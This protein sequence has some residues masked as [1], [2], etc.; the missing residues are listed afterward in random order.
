MIRMPRFFAALVFAALLLAGL[1]PSAAL[2]DGFII[3]H[4]P[5][6]VPPGHFPFAPLEV[7]YHRVDVSIDEQ[8][9]ITSVDQEFHNPNPTRMEGTYLF[10]LP[11][12]AHLDSFKMDIDGRMAEA[13][14]LS[15]EK[16]R[17]IYED[18]VRRQRDPAL[19]E[20]IGREAL[21][22]RIFPIEPNSNKKIKLR[23]T[24]LLTADAGLVEYVY[25]L[26]TEK[27]SAKPLRDVSV[28]VSLACK[29]P[30]RSIY[31]PSHNVEVSWDGPTRAKVG[32]EQHDVR[33]DT[34]F[35]LIWSRT[36]DPVGV[37]LLTFK[38]S[39]Q[40]GYFLLLASPGFT[41]PGEAPQPRD[42]CFVLDTSGSMAGAKLDQAKKALLFCLANLNPQD[43]FQIVRFSTEAE[44]L[45][46]ALEP[47][48]QAHIATARQFVDGL[49]PIG[50]TAIA[51]ALHEAMSLAGRGEKRPL[52]IIFLT[53]GQPTVGE[54]NEDKIVAQ[55][56]REAKQARAFVFGIGSDINTHLLD[57]IANQTKAFSQ[58]VLPAED[59]ELKVSS[60]YTKIK[61]PALTDVQVA[62]T[63]AVRTSAIYP[64]DMPDLYAG[65]ALSVFGRYSGDGAAAVRISGWMD[66]Q[67]RE[68]VTDVS[69]TANDTSR[70]YIPRLWATRR[71]GWLLDE[72]RLHGESKELVDEIVSLAREHGIVTPYTAYLIVEDERRRD[73]PV[74]LRSMRELSMSD[75]GLE[76]ARRSYRSAAGGSRT[77]EKVGD[78]AVHNAQAAQQLKWG[79]NES[80]STVSADLDKP[81]DGQS[82]LG[83]GYRSATNFTQ[84]VA[85]RAG[86]TFY[87]NGQT[88]TDASA[89][90]KQNLRRQEVAFNSDDYFALLRQ[91]PEAGQ[92]L[93][94]G[95][96]VDLV[97]GDT[98]YVVR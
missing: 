68:F 2:A 72:I 86:K 91:F 21:K 79:V 66:G 88:W 77:L 5:P 19:L 29:Q 17:A 9:A 93:S 14:L 32:Y 90:V 45:F 96:E 36:A 22:V 63:G 80:Q 46:D 4:D 61:Q 40:D 58:Y 97:I 57:R 78:R 38:Q 56:Q 81:E 49:K 65:E 31:C 89:Q 7:V 55:V 52:T 33:P 59:I 8:V 64:G 41:V 75:D 24:Q 85:R 11:P 25:P 23:Y 16:A 44:G 34:D 84:Q 51:D 60:F 50:G 13:E 74:P 27:F 43:R 47:A 71:V 48:D 18:I 42:I 94:L 83:A 95:S 39:P 98:L 1:A 67:R 10:P 12:G 54:T 76:L 20:Y 69:F 70:A 53:D 26:N 3:V 35:K 73:V 15:A 82:V 6:H 28:T 30:I 37:D 87:Q 62:F 92:W